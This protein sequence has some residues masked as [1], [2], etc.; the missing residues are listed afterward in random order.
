MTEIFTEKE[1]R[2]N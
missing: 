1:I 2:G